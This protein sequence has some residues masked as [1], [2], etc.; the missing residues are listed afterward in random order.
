MAADNKKLTARRKEEIEEIARWAYEDIFAADEL[1]RPE[2]IARQLGITYTLGNYDQSFKGLIEYRRGR[3][4]I[5]LHTDHNEQIR[6][7]QVRYSFA[8]EL[9]HYFIDE[10]R[11]KLESMGVLPKDPASPMLAESILEK[12]AEYFAACLLMPR[13][14]F[15]ADV[16]FKEFSPALILE[17]CQKYRVS[18]SAALF[19]YMA[20]GEVPLCIINS[21]VNGEYKYHLKSRQFPFYTLA[22]DENNMI[23]VASRAGDYCYN[24][25][26]DFATPLVLPA[27]TWFYPKTEADSLRFFAEACYLQKMAGRVMSVIWEVKF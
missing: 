12:E 23:P 3:Y 27:S 4:H 9:G 16:S 5:Y 14:R 13:E 20:L 11:W 15:I 2:V 21:T 8:H 1:I 17:I 6:S 18:L 19:R 22:L 24:S 26:S 7:T 10:H 25:I